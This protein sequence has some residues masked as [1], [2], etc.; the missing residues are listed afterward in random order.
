MI[1]TITLLLFIVTSVISIKAIHSDDEKYITITKVLFYISALSYV[2][3]GIT[4]VD[5]SSEEHF[6]ELIFTIWGYFYLLALL[7]III[8]LYLNFSKW[9]KHWKSIIAIAAPFITIL[10]ILSIPFLE[11]ERRF[12]FDTGHSLATKHMLP[13]HII[14]NLIGELFFFFS[15]IGSILYLVMERQLRKKTSMKLI[16]R[17][18]SLESIESF[19]RWAISRS[20]LLL[21]AGII[22][23]MI[24]A[25]LNYSVISLGTAKEMHIYFSWFVILGIFLIRKTMMMTSRRVSIINIALFIIVMFLFIFTNIFI[26]SGFHSFK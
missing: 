17:L 18:P 20:L 14:I 25:F 1:F 9:K 22:I 10:I 5:F 21:S 3:L 7:L 12:A 13:A 4:K 16:Y 6:K 24:M 19:N 15:F 11:S 2:I 8:I 26:T 23:G